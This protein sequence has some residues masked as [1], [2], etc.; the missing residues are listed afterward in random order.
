MWQLYSEHQFENYLHPASWQV[1]MAQPEFCLVLYLNQVLAHIATRLLRRHRSN[2]FSKREAESWA[3]STRAY[4]CR[5][6]HIDHDSKVSFL[7]PLLPPVNFKDGS[8]SLAHWGDLAPIHRPCPEF[9]FLK[10]GCFGVG[11][12]P[13]KTTAMFS[14]DMGT[15]ETSW[16]F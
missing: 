3:Y 16:V 12:M 6:A 7:V 15:W 14:T 1:K 5:Q 10:S 4:H 13:N 11:C 2:I 9:L 8:A